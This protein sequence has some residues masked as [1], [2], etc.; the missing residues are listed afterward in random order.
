MEEAR[1]GVLEGPEYEMFGDVEDIRLDEKHRIYVLDKQASAIRVFEKDGSFVRSLGGEGGGPGE[2]RLATGMTFAPDGLLWVL[3]RNNLRYSI[4][5]SSGTLVRE[6]RRPGT[7]SFWWGWSG[8]FS[9]DGDY[10]DIVSSVIKGFPKVGY[11]KYDTTTQQ[12]VDTLW[13]P[14]PDT[15]EHVP[16]GIGFRMVMASRRWYGRRQISVA[17]N[18][19]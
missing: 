2:F 6:L 5:D 13:D 15:R 7:S 18:I 3:N 19:V 11:V 1:I 12:F 10:Y 14:D 8:M 16:R 4:F 17:R 9:D